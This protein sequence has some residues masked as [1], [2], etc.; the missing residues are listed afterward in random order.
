MIHDAQEHCYRWEEVC[1]RQHHGLPTPVG[2]QQSQRELHVA[3]MNYLRQLYR[4]KSE[5]PAEDIWAEEEVFE[6]NQGDSVT[7]ADIFSVGEYRWS[8]NS[9]TVNGDVQDTSQTMTVP[10]LMKVI[11]QADEMAHELQFDAQPGE[12]E[13]DPEEAMV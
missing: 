10:K 6:T 7:L 1:L 5:K 4:F 3:V 9:S 2:E 11:S 8:G 13:A 12:A